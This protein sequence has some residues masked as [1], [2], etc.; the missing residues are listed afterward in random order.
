M[1]KKRVSLKGLIITLG[2]LFVVWIIV[3]KDEAPKEEEKNA[4]IYFIMHP[5]LKH[6]AIEKT[7]NKG[8]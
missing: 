4:E 7:R 1:G 2:L 6:L 3:P 8:V 5:V